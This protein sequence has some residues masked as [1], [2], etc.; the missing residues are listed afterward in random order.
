MVI[1]LCYFLNFYSMKNDLESLIYNGLSSLLCQY[2][3]ES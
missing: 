2:E 1:V 3:Q